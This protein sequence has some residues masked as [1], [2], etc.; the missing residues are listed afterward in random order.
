MYLEVRKKRGEVGLM[1]VRG[2][3]PSARRLVFKSRLIT[4]ATNKSLWLFSRA[5]VMSFV[6]AIID[7]EF[8]ESLINFEKVAPSKSCDNR[9]VRMRRMESSTQRQFSCSG[10]SS[11]VE[12][13]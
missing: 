3:Q 8:Y 12:K 7:L 6:L 13:G 4:R 1:H 2:S 5:V 10:Q 11:D 9:R